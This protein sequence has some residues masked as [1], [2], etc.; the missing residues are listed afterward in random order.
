VKCI[1][2]AKNEEADL[3]ATVKNCTNLD[4]KEKVSLETLLAYI[5]MKTR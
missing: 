4:N 1:P 5:S 2:D 3:K